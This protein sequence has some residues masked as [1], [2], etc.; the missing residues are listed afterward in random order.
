[1]HNCRTIL[2]WWTFL[3][4][5]TTADS[6]S[7]R[8]GESLLPVK[9]AYRCCK[10]K[11]FTKSLLPSKAS[12]NTASHLRWRP[13]VVISSAGRRYHDSSIS[14]SLLM[15][16]S[17]LRVAICA[18]HLHN[19]PCSLEAFDWFS[20]LNDYKSMQMSPDESTSYAE[21]V[22]MVLSRSAWKGRHCL[23]YTI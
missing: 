20:L 23:I 1:M 10:D 22:C 19:E 18:F 7:I 17:W 8:E 14:D 6:K 15:F 5:Q 9:A 21:L 2:S 3:G 4:T 13:E 16:A 11:F 12:A